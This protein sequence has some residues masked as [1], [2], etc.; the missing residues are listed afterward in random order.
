MNTATIGLVDSPLLD[1]LD[2]GV[3]AELD[4]RLPT[5]TCRKGELVYSP[6]D[7]AET[8]YLLQEGRVRLYRSAGDGRQL[9]IAII[10]PG[11]AF[12]ALAP[13]EHA[14]HDGYACAMSDCVLRVI[15]PAELERAIMLEP[16]LAANLLRVVAARLR[17][18][19]DQLESLAF[20]GVSSRLA[21]KLLDLM[22]RY[23][24]VTPRGIRIDER[25]THVQLAEMIGTSRETLTKVLSELRDTGVVDVRDR[26]VWVLD[27]DRL[28][29]LKTAA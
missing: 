8:L 4:E 25:F 1:G 23:G 27:P 14:L 15:R 13:T 18:A 3:L 5:V 11:D 26:M 6:Y 21:G 12:G 16:R 22:D 29:R 28:E 2:E 20:R 17:D 19:E 7:P 9:T 10:D 24:R